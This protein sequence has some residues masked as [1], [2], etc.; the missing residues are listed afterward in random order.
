[1][2]F[3]GPLTFTPSW[4]LRH[5]F[6]T[7]DDGNIHPSMPATAKRVDAWVRAA[8]HA[9]GRPDWI[10]VKVFGHAISSDGDAEA[11]LGPD[12]DSALRHLETRYNDGARYVLHYVTAREAYNIVRAAMDG[13]GG[14][15]DAY[16]DWDV[17][18]YVADRRRD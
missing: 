15:P 16:R 10:F 6:V 1:M 7:A 5:L 2:I 3:E 17:K 8:V 9:P 4:N 11:A 13:R 12:F 18:P 14:D